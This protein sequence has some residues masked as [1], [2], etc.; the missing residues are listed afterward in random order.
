MVTCPSLQPSPAVLPSYRLPCPYSSVVQHVGV[1]FA[2]DYP[3][4]ELFST[5]E[6]GVDFDADNL[7]MQVVLPPHLLSLAGGLSK[8]QSD[9]AGRAG[10]GWY[11]V[12]DRLPFNP[13]TGCSR[14]ARGLT[15]FALCRTTCSRAAS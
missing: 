12:F 1:Q 13:W 2:G 11:E 14:W 8:V 3:D 6:F 10:R 9:I 7:E 15:S 5:L 4:R